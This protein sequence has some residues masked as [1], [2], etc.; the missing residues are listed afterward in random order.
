[1]TS[2]ATCPVLCNHDDVINRKHIPRHWTFV[3]GF[4]RSTV[5]SPHKGQWHGALMFSFDL[6][7]NKR[8]SKQS[9]GWR[10][11]T[12]SRQLWRHCN[13]YALPWWYYVITQVP[14][15]PANHQ[16]SGIAFLGP[17]LGKSMSSELKSYE[18]SFVSQLDLIVQS[19]RKFGICKDRLSWC[20]MC[21]KWDLIEG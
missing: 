3:R 7:P 21:K 13:G 5:N 4:H 19:G 20:G 11:E 10:F 2:R 1:M 15:V 6:R 14:H 12:L 9:W 18:S 17:V 16:C 8:L